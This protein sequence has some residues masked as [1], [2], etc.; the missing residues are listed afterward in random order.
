MHSCL[1]YLDICT[2]LTNEMDWVAQILEANILP[3]LLKLSPWLNKVDS[4][5]HP[6][7]I[8]LRHILP[9]YLVYASILKSVEKSL[10]KVA[11]LDLDAHG[12]KVG[13]FW[14]VWNSFKSLAE[15]C[16]RLKAEVMQNWEVPVH[17]RMCNN[18]KVCFCSVIPF[19][20]MSPLTSTVYEYRFY[21]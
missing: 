15:E 10:K 7:L 17:L 8:L 11:T 3:T 9:I 13:P 2:S 1:A 12:P 6:N 18:P 19:C 16:S 4:D 20:L 5:S 21:G 14:N